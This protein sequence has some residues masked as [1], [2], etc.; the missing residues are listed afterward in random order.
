MDERLY[1]AAGH[2][3]FTREREEPFRFSIPRVP[4][5][6]T[7]VVEEYAVGVRPYQAGPRATF[8]DY[9]ALADPLLARLPTRDRLEWRIGHFARDVPAGYKVAR[10]TGSTAL[11]NRN[12]AAYYQ[13]LRL[14]TAGPIFD[15]ERLKTVVRFNL[16]RYRDLRETYVERI[17]R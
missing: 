9:Y 16:G 5:W 1:F 10:E 14:I 17:Q 15:P 4:P 13:R 2:A 3:L 7:M 8:I 12:L 11:M 6:P